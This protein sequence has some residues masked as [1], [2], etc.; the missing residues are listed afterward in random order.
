[1]KGFDY[2]QPGR[3]EEA[4]GLME[5]LGAEAG[6]IAGGTDILVRMKQKIIAPPALISL[7]RIEELARMGRDRGLLLGSMTP[8]RALEKS[9]EIAASHPCLSQAVGSLANPQ[10]RNVA[11]VGGNL[12]NAAPSADCAPPLMVL[13]ATLTIGGPGGER[14]LPVEDFFEGP[15][16]TVLR[17]EEILTGIAIPERVPG[18]GSAFLKLGRVSQDIAVINAAALVIMEGGV[19]RTCRLAVGA[20]APT[21]LR[22][23]GVERLVEGRR[24][25]PELLAE[26]ERGVRGEVNPITD[27]RS[28]EEYRR[29]VSGVLL[30]RALEQAVRDVR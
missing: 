26:V 10:I 27:V 16:R 9:E 20:V 18:T 3:L 13:G 7:R 28:T 23:R 4:Y 21:P 24:P 14:T 2:F 17:R 8:L 12:C 25:D 11:T 6:Y 29:E 22:L 30:R 5:T 19:C 1:M 15:G